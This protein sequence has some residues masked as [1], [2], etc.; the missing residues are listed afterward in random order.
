MHQ[1]NAR[2]GVVVRY[3]IFGIGEGIRC[4]LERQFWALHST[5]DIIVDAS[6]SARNKGVRPGMSKKAAKSLIPELELVLEEEHVTGSLQ[7]V[8]YRV[9]RYTPWIQKV[10]ED[11]FLFQIPGDRP[12]MK[13]VRRIL[14]DMEQVLGPEQRLQ[15]AMA[16][17][18]YMARTI[19][20]WS[21]VEK[22]P[23]VLYFR[24]DGDLWLI[25]PSI[26]SELHQKVGFSILGWLGELPIPAFWIAPPEARE[27]LM[28][29]GV[30]RLKELAHIPTSYLE[31]QFG[32]SA[33]HWLAWLEQLPRG[34]V[35]I[36]FPPDETIFEWMPDAGDEAPVQVLEEIL[37]KLTGEMA[38]VLQQRRVGA[39]RLTLQWETERSITKVE[40]KFKQ[41]VFENEV[42]LSGI[43]AELRNERDWAEKK[44]HESGVR[45]RQGRQ[46][47]RVCFTANRLQPL[48][49]AQMQLPD[50]SSAQKQMVSTNLHRVVRHVNRKFPGGLQMGI[51]PTFRELRLQ[52]VLSA[53]GAEFH[54]NSRRMG[55]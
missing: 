27:R 28:S 53:S 6:V 1:Q 51:H 41:P 17:T 21:R 54:L 16:E 55:L 8:L 45:V 47:S 42:I 43:L 19:V 20:E 22:V 18:P 40:R 7:K 32:K 11:S 38:E 37:S 4:D 31:R 44:E 26:A 36:N 9:S 29:L 5:S 49:S 15:I 52:A 50:S 10:N 23:D 13:E 3:T 39:L 30:H 33:L 2:G 14:E 35:Q 25:S 34:M 48:V 46:L 12:P 24:V